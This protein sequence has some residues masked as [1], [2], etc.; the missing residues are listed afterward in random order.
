MTPSTAANYME[1]ANF[2]NSQVIAAQYDAV[3]S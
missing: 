2:M 1:P 3:Y